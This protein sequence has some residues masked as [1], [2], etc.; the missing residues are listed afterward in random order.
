VETTDK[1]DR[2]MSD[3]NVILARLAVI[4]VQLAAGGTLNT[5]HEQRIRTVERWMWGV[6][7][8][9]VAGLAGLAVALKP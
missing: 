2:I 3:Q 1:L 7:A 4:E 6:P 9:L 8:S 5:D